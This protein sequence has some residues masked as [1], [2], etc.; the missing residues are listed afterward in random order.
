MKQYTILKLF[1]LAILTMITLIIISILEVAV[2]SYFIN[3][4]QDFS[5]YEAHAEITAPY[6]SG[7]FGFIIFFLVARY[8]K[9]KEFPNLLKLIFL[10]PLIYVLLDF[11]IIVIDGTVEWSS[12]I[13]IF[14]LAN[15]AKILDSFLGY[16]LAK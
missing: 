7:I 16:R 2:Y 8:W 10:F 1:G 3:P 11:T 4:R 9:R 5:V 15:G 13:L 14:T 6:V 12:F